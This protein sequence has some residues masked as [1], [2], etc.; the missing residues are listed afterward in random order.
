M[1]IT[2]LLG[3]LGTL[4]GLVRA[5]PQL[6]SLLRAKQARGVSV[7]TAATSSI[8]SFGWTAYGLFTNQPY[9]V[10]ATGSSA[11]VFFLVA[12]FALRYGRHIREVKIAP[13]WFC[14]LLLAALTKKELG[15][16]VILPVSVLISNVPQLWVAWKEDNLADLS[17]GTWLLSMSD[18]TVWGAYSLIQHDTSIMTFA[19][20]QL[21][22]SGMI[23]LLKLLKR[24]YIRKKTSY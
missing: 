18:G 13:V 8:V 11:M 23:V 10:L 5:L 15:L 17:L 4:I 3:L 6:F 20:F 1:T 22:T 16:G 14:I 12:F 2:S 7:D 19:F 24:E 9:V 21:T